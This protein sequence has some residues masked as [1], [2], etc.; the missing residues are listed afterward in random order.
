MDEM[1]RSGRSAGKRIKIMLIDDHPTLLLGLSAILKETGEYE[2]A[3]TGGD[4]A[5]AVALA[6]K[7]QPDIVLLD[8]SMPGD[9]FLA[10][11]T[12][13]GQS[14]AIKIV[15]F[16]A[17]AEVGLA[18]RAMQVGASGFLLKGSPIAEL[19]RAIAA[20]LSG[21]TYISADVSAAL[22][23]PGP[24][25]PRTTPLSAREMQVLDCLLK[26]MSNKE[27]AQAL[28]LT[29]KTVKHYMTNLMGKLKA[30]NRLDAVLAARRLGLAPQPIA[31]PGLA[32]SPQE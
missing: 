31:A 3:G 29:E 11:E 23:T 25:S 22:A 13:L 14:P 1:S 15:V 30:R 27:I 12:I 28:R 17:Y 6:A 21:Q 19:H 5:E 32:P 16:T 7:T 9:A 24:S 2:I 8:L 26:A 20:A 18:R 10:I 4:A